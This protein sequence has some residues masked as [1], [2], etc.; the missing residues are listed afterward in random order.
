MSFNLS[1]E[2]K[3]FRLLY[4]RMVAPGD[5]VRQLLDEGEVGEEQLLRGAGRG[6]GV[7]FHGLHEGSWTG[8]FLV[9]RRILQELGWEFLGEGP[10]L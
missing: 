7:V 6:G 2:P 8:E 1:S 5:Q 10:S 9:V 3:L 4:A